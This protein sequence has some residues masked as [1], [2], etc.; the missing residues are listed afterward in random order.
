M[1]IG[2][3]NGL[4]AGNVTIGLCGVLAWSW[5]IGR[6]R[7]PPLAIAVVGVAKIFPAV[8]VCWTTPP[9]FLRSV[10]TAGL[11]A[12]GW[13]LVT[14]PFV[15]LNSWFDFLRSLGNAQPMCSYGPSVSCVLQPAL[16]VSAAKLAALVLA[17]ALGLGA[18]LV[19]TDLIAFT[20]IAI[21]WIVPVSDLSNYSVMPIFVVW[22]VV[23]AIAMRRMRS[24]DP[25]SP[26]AAL[27]RFRPW[28]SRFRA[29]A[30]DR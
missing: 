1:W 7:T 14:L 4:A 28:S 13:L 22:V 19:R 2:F 8:L 6:D 9:R 15:G 16:G 24:L 30:G 25:G 20:M 11:I 3:L 29:R 23:F 18:V 27:R 10:A 5:A 26:V 17:G 21:A 12:A